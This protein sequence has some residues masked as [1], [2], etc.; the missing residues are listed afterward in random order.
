MHT[1]QLKGS[2]T[3]VRSHIV[4]K[5][6]A[7]LNTHTIFFKNHIDDDLAEE[8]KIIAELLE[9]Q[10]YFCTA[11]E[12]NPVTRKWT[13]CQRKLHLLFNNDS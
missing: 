3:G 13:V 1:Y 8:I 5:A 7:L 12:M 11:A 6:R 10:K 4:N 9:S 2:L